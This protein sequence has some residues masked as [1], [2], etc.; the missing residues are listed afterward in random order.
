MVVAELQITTSCM[1]TVTLARINI[2]SARPLGTVRQ[3]VT[4]AEPMAKVK[5]RSCH[6]RVAPTK[7]QVKD[8]EP[9]KGVAAQPG[10]DLGK[11]C[12][13]MAAAKVAVGN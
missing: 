3:L 1:T 13:M 11:S 10:T 4:M 8:I 9:A 2:K 6:F 7:H 5:G 12:L